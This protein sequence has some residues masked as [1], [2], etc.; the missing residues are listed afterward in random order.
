MIATVPH[1]QMSKDVAYLHMLVH[2]FWLAADPVSRH[3][4]LPIVHR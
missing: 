1:L 2:V 4:H 3:Q